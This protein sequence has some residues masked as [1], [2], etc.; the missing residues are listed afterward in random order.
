MKALSKF[1]VLVAALVLASCGGGGGG[2][3]SAFTPTPA[4]TIEIA[5]ASTSIYTNS[6]TTLTVT[7]KKADGSIENDGTT[8]NA[9]VSPSTIGTVSGAAG[10]PAGTT[11]SNTLAGGK[12]TFNFT[13]SN[14]AGSATIT[15]SVPAGVNG[16]TTAVAKSVGITVNSGNTQDP[17]L[18]LDTPTTT[19]PLNPFGIG[20]SQTPPYPGNYIGSPYIAEV[21]VTWRHSN[22]QLVNG[23]NCVNVSAQPVSIIA[24]SQ[25]ISQGGDGCNIPQPTDGDLFH[26]LEGSGP[27]A[28]TAG[29]GTIFVHSS[30]IPGS[31]ILTVTAIDPDNNQTISSQLQFTVAGAASSLP[32]S[33]VTYSTGG[34]Y[35]SGSGGPQSAVVNAAIYDGNNALVPDPAGFDNVRFEIAG[36][37]GTD[38]RLSGINA[39]GQTVSGNTVSTVT[40]NGVATVS[41]L[42][43]VQQGP[44][45]IRAI[46]DRG[47]GNVDNGVQDAV[48]STVTV[49]ISDGKL[50]SLT[51]TGPDTNAILIN[52]VS[53]DTTLVD[54]GGSIP[55]DPNGTYSLTVAALGVDRQG[56]P[57]LPGTVVKF[58]SIDAPQSN[59]LF[60]ISGTQGNPAEGGTLFTAADG[61]FR[62][63][64]GGAGP[65][66]TLLVFG[67]DVVGNSDLESAATIKSIS[68]ETSLNVQTP[69]NRNDTTGTSVDYGNVLPYIIGR[70]QTGNIFSPS[71]TNA[72]GVATTTLNYP[73]SALG[74]TV[75]IWAQSTSTD[76]VTGGT[77]IV[78]DAAVTAFPGV[79]PAT[80][81]ISPNPIPGNITLEVD[82]CIFD[83]LKSPISGVYF[84]FAFQDMGIGSGKLDGISGAGVVPDPTGPSGCVATTVT[85]NGIG[86]NSGG[87]PTLTF[88][89]GDAS[90]SAPITAAGDLIL[91]ARPS[92]LGGQGGTV[93]LQLLTSN[94][95][96]V[97]G[98]QLVGTC[99]GDPS[100]GIASG[101]GVTD[102]QGKTTA[103]IQADLDQVGGGKSGSCTFTTASGAPT[104]VVT[105]NGIDVCTTSPHPIACDDGSGTPTTKNLTVNL[106]ANGTGFGS[107]TSAPSGIDCVMVSSVEVSCNYAFPT[108]TVVALSANLLNGA[109]GVTWSGACSLSGTSLNA[110]VT[111]NNDR[112][113]TATFSGP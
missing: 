33:V 57:V 85:T 37:A 75:A 11:A 56:N 91:L 84:D 95:A 23:T 26:N 106:F 77:N 108:G 105:L 42:A 68:S 81:V 110:S 6:F 44:V 72:Y 64:G 66:D 74:R 79:A 102:S 83:A 86:S 9:S 76:F 87:N 8:I 90:E 52:R 103:V 13:S 21:T 94:G 61:H 80:I 62:T 51:L 98:V 58:G 25:L 48:S 41:V 47:D 31:G 35:V 100:I 73:V 2:S 30:V 38:A 97:P 40:H 15:V 67:K 69:F 89:A 19:L 49:I 65:G 63:A 50:F 16:S 36:P 3:K 1:F 55:P 7:V 34:A 70:A 112:V 24:F 17:R 53:G 60:L 45:Q 92:A 46:A 39:A 109:T 78:T 5:V 111:V 29:V 10:S 43:G 88:T 96:P 18:K 12:T 113:C 22:G 28:V 104:A 82:V 107:V 99:S 14:Q 93:T 71:A 4:D 54:G 59:G 32:T 20:E 101:P 27:V